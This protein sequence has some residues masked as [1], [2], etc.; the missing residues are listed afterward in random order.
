MSAEIQR[1]VTFIVKER[2]VGE[3]VFLAVE[4]YG[5]T[6]GAQSI[7]AYLELPPGTDLNRAGEIAKFLK[8][9]VADLWFANVKA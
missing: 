6:K 8:A 5:E 7:D 1:N 3:P 2:G 4:Y 9:N